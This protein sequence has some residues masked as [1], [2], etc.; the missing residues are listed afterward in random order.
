MAIS[1]ILLPDVK[2]AMTWAKLTCP[3]W[4]TTGFPVWPF[5]RV[6]LRGMVTCTH[7]ACCQGMVLE[8]TVIRYRPESIAKPGPEYTAIKFRMRP[9]ASVDV[10]EGLLKFDYI[11]LSLH[12]RFLDLRGKRKPR[13]P[14]LFDYM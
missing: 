12:T 10:P 4:T 2:Y 3:L 14:S 6:A 9:E 13:M 11:A 8:G 7:L 5:I 1:G